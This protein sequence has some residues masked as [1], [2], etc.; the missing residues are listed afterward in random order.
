MAEYNDPTHVPEIDKEIS[1]GEKD[2][3]S[4]KLANWIRTKMYGLDVREA[5]A[6]FILW[7]SVLYHRILSITDKLIKRQDDVEHKFD[8]LNDKFNDQ[9][10]GSTTDG[11]IIAARRSGISGKKYKLLGDR[12]DDMEESHFTL[13]EKEVGVL[14]T[15]QDDRFSI[16]YEVQKTIEVND[17]SDFSAL[18]I[19]EI[20]NTVQDTFYLEKVGEI[21]V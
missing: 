16:N 21:D 11:E 17:S 6:R 20:G 10:E 18:V 7:I 15:L 4:V 3:I 13:K 2:A 1:E 19:A 9:I 8:N 14:I 12:L 5:M